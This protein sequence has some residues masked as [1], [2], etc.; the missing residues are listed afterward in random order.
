MQDSYDKGF[1]LNYQLVESLDAEYILFD[2][3]TNK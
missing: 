1:G 3:G 2:L